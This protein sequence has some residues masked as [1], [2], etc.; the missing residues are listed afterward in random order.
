[1]NCEK[2]LNKFKVINRNVE[3]QIKKQKIGHTLTLIQL[4]F[5]E[6][7]QKANNKLKKINNR[8]PYI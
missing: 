7:I 2:L 1:V 8:Y 6:D 3:L 5:F 4:S